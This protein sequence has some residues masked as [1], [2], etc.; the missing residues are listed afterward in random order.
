MRPLPFFPLLPS[1]VDVAAK[2]GQENGVIRGRL[3]TRHLGLFPKRRAG[4]QAGVMASRGQPADQTAHVLPLLQSGC[5]Q[6]LSAGESTGCPRA[7][8]SEHP[9]ACF[10][11]S[12]LSQDTVHPPYL[13]NCHL[14]LGNQ[15]FIIASFFTQLSHTR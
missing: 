4:A 9:H 1:V 7:V 11:C 3:H 12:S 2:P 13:P 15:S 10:T 8:S 14:G 6:D 5:S